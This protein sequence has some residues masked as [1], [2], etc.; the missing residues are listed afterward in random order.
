MWAN[1]S[2]G[3]AQRVDVAAPGRPDAAGAPSV[4]SA[5]L[6]VG[7]HD[8]HRQC[9]RSIAG[10]FQTGLAGAD[11]GFATS[12]AFDPSGRFA[13]L[14]DT[15]CER[16]IARPGYGAGQR[17]KT[18]SNFACAARGPFLCEHGQQFGVRGGPAAFPAPKPIA[19][20]RILI[21]TWALPILVKP[22]GRGPAS[23]QL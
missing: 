3:Q 11:D 9:A 4:Q 14:L 17:G 23:R 8:I 21:E 20:Q 7:V 19:A 5:H 18:P 6:I 13:D 12:V 15:N 1:K 2:H 10:F 16:R 22:R